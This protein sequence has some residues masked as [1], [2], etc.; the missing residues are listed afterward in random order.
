VA[1]QAI[2][3]FD[4]DKDYIYFATSLSANGLPDKTPPVFFAVWDIVKEEVV[5]RHEFDQK[6]PIGPIAALPG[7]Q[8]VYVNTGDKLL[9]YD[10]DRRGFSGEIG[11]GRSISTPR[12]VIKNG[13]MLFGQGN[14]IMCLDPAT[15][16]RTVIATAPGRVSLL[17]CAADGALYF[18]CEAELYRVGSWQ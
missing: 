7:T 4:V 9:V 2:A 3:S 13:K 1:E 11:L 14:N 16:E 17:T 18:M 15:G 6:Q 12:I 10:K 8:K 5:F